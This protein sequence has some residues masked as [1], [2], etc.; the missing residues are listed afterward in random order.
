MQSPAYSLRQTVPCLSDSFQ[1]VFAVRWPSQLDLTRS[2]CHS[3]SSVSATTVS[4]ST[5]LAIL[6]IH[7]LNFYSWIFISLLTTSPISKIIFVASPS[8]RHE[9]LSFS[10]K[11]SHSLD[12]VQSPNHHYSESSRPLTFSLQIPSIVRSHFPLVRLLLI[13]TTCCKDY[14][15]DGNIHHDYKRQS[16]NGLKLHNAIL[17]FLQFLCAFILHQ[18]CDRLH[19][20]HLNTIFDT[21]K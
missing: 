7:A 18:H 3:R 21:Q 6:S 10:S 5:T 20:N 13:P 4:R 17:R 12:Y 15:V 11:P 2:V 9:H 14:R 1:P 16:F 8:A 19:F